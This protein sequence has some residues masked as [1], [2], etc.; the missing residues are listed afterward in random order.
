MVERKHFPKEAEPEEVVGEIDPGGPLGKCWCLSGA[1]GGLQAQS[2]GQMTSWQPLFHVCHARARLDS[3]APPPTARISTWA[4]KSK[5]V[6]K[7]ITSR[8][9][10]ITRA[11]FASL[12]T[13]TCSHGDSF[14][15]DANWRYGPSGCY[16]D[17]GLNEHGLPDYF[18]A[19]GDKDAKSPMV[20]A[21]DLFGDPV[22]KSDSSIYICNPA[23]VLRW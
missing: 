19:G 4:D 13:V 11:A 3:I 21:S 10:S 23:D 15:V 8:A 18:L 7:Q 12:R 6:G 17:S 9:M 5:G 16:K 2:W 22:S 20:Y 14:F 1:E